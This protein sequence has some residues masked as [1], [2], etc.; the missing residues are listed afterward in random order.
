[1]L[2]SIECEDPVIFFEHKLLS[3][4]WLGNMGIGGRRTVEF[5]VPTEGASGPVPDK[6]TPLPLGKAALKREGKDITL[7]SVG[8]GVFRCLEA[9][10]LLK[11]K[12][13]EAGVIDLRS[14]HPL[15]KETVLNEV[16]TTGRML[17]VDEDYKHFGLSGELAA[18]ALEEGIPFKFSRV[19]TEQTIPF[20]RRLEDEIL[21]NTKKILEAAEKLFF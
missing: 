8:V 10:S 19:C 11:L 2:A 21:P 16:A 14:V 18:I 6:W 3:E 15:D 5:D 20:S 12:G 13:I 1:M 9:A 17:V 7:I 4:F